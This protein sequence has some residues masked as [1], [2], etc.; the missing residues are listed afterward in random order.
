MM[1]ALKV[2]GFMV[3]MLAA[4]LLLVVVVCTLLNFRTPSPTDLLESGHLTA[5]PEPLSETLTVRVVT[6]NVWDL[7]VMGTHRRERMRAIGRVLAGLEPDVVGLQ[8]AFWP[9]DR[10]A[11][12][13]ELAGTGLVHSRYFRSG[14][15]GSG[16]LVV[17]RFPIREAFFHRYTRGGNPL[18]VWHGDWWAGKGVCLTR[19]ELPNGAGYLDFFNTHAHAGY[20][21]PAYDAVRLSNMQEHAAFMNRAV[22]GTAPAISAGDYNC[23]EGTPQWEAFTLGADL[24]RMM[25]IPSKI[26]H[27]FAKANPLYDF[28]AVETVAIEDTLDI[29]GEQIDLSDHTGYMTTIRIRPRSIVE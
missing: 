29:G 13:G 11:L 16:L 25:T 8:E 28:E 4:V 18:K 3:A 26:D 24:A 10:E 27:V 17:S 22:S 23:R 19:L 7:R 2:M 21:E 20:G 6:Y 1:K 5:P 9:K 15:V 14:L 12:L